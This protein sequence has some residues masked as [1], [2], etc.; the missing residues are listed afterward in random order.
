MFNLV[1]LIYEMKNKCVFSTWN[2]RNNSSMDTY[3]VIVSKVHD[4][5][6]T[7]LNQ[8]DFKLLPLRNILDAAV[9]AQARYPGSDLVES[10][11]VNIS[12]F[13]KFKTHCD[14]IFRYESYSVCYIKKLCAILHVELT[15]FEVVTIMRELSNMLNSKDIVVEDDHSNPEYQKTLLSQQHN[16]SNGA[17]NKF[18]QLS[19]TQL[20]R[21]LDDEQIESFLA[22]HGYI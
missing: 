13:N 8:F 5:E 2:H 20:L 9:S 15:N 18:I 7:Y 22:E 19:N 16:T 3:D 6:L 21:L 10:C 12:L 17:S 14:F 4:V 11:L 1:R